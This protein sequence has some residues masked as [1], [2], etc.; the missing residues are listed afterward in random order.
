MANR[1]AAFVVLALPVLLVACSGSS[2]SAGPPDGAALFK[3]HC[4][5]CHGL[6]GKGLVAKID[7]TSPQWQSAHTDEQIAC[8]VK[9]GIQAK[10][11]SMPPFKTVLK[12]DEIQAI[13]KDM[14]RKF[15]KEGK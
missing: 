11:K 13:I 14:I 2:P 12:D 8:T 6:D 10:D 9:Q 7:M 1:Y 3:K 15:G 4:A 5:S